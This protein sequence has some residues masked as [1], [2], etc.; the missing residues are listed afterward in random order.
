[1]NLIVFNGVGNKL[2]KQ[3]L[4]ELEGA[5]NK[6][7]RQNIATPLILAAVSGTVSIQS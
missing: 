2:W 3:G 4:G 6:F 1:M 5:Q 7:W